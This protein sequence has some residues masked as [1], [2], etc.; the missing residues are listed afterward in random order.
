MPPLIVRGC[1]HQFK[2]G[3]TNANSKILAPVANIDEDVI[4]VEGQ[5]IDSSVTPLAAD[6]AKFG[7]QVQI[8]ESFE[9]E[10]GG[11]T[12]FGEAA[13][14]LIRGANIGYSPDEGEFTIRIDGGTDRDDVRVEYRPVERPSVQIISPSSNPYTTDQQTL[15]VRAR[16]RGITRANQVTKPN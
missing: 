13:A 5:R 14:G 4:V 16:T 11:F 15:R 9:I 12:N 6:F 7:T 2:P 1:I 3:S 10:T 8:I